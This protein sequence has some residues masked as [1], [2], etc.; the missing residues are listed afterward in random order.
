[1]ARITIEDVRAVIEEKGWKLISETYENL[2]TEMIFE[3][4]KGHRIYSPWKKLR[5][6]CECP[7]CAQNKLITPDGKI[8]PKPHGARRV[9]A[10][11]QASHTS[12]FAIYDNKKLVFY[13]TFV[14]SDESEDGRIDQVKIW[15]LSMIKAWAPDYIAIEGIQYQDK[16]EAAGEAKTSVTLFQT[17]AR[18]QGVLLNVC[19]E[20]NI[21]HEVCP[22]NTW[23]HFC[24]VK[25]R[26]RADKKR[27]MQLLVEEWYQ[28]KVSDDIADAIGIGHYYANSVAQQ[29][30]IVNWE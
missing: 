20:A 17:L 15:L 22:T 11:D 21:P 8:V 26:S 24:G 4:D 23:R 29:T 3:C 28:I 18:L 9:L 13:G 5:N 19:Y 12:G 6:K 10:L 16:N 1:M 27:S 25:G 2:D 30:E 7:A 14:T